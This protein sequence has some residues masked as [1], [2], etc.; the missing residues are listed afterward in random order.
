M[1][2]LADSSKDLQPRNRIPR[3]HECGRIG[4]LGTLDGIRRTVSG[5]L[6]ATLGTCCKSVNSRVDG[7]LWMSIRP[8]HGLFR[9]LKARFPQSRGLSTA[10]T[11]DLASRRTFS[12]GSY[13]C[14]LRSAY[15]RPFG[16]YNMAHLARSTGET[17]RAVLGPLPDDMTPT[18]DRDGR[19]AK[20]P[21]ETRPLG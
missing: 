10:G 4:G 7:L 20:R 18:V 11:V 2:A 15:S 16:I 8:Q 13:R 21:S 14:G 19:F 6:R 9:P 1:S 17:R 3:Y 5:P 12:T